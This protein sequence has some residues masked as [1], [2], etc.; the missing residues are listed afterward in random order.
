[1]DLWDEG[2][3][4]LKGVFGASGFSLTHEAVRKWVIFFAGIEVSKYGNPSRITLLR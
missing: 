1:M 4:M 2:W 3:D